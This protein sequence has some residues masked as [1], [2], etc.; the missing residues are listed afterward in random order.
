[1]RRL[2]QGIFTVLTPLLLLLLL[3]P[4]S[5]R[6]LLTAVGASCNEDRGT[7]YLPV[8]TDTAID[9][10]YR[11]SREQPAKKHASRLQ[12][13]HAVGY[14]FLML[15]TFNGVFRCA[16]CAEG[17]RALSYHGMTSIGSCLSP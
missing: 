10:G 17:A 7:G 16:L 3:S 9:E 15:G 8:A 5:R 14:Y 13:R 1:M 2:S 4:R 11:E 6:P 12:T